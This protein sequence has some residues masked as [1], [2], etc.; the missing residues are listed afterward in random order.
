M[1]RLVILRLMSTPLSVS[2]VNTICFLATGDLVRAVPAP[3]GVASAGWLCVAF[4]KPY[5]GDTGCEY[6]SSLFPFFI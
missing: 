4:R 1:L 5:A 6:C 3:G 2:Y